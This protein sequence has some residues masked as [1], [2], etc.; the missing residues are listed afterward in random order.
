MP[1][2]CATESVGASSSGAPV[3]VLPASEWDREPY[4]G[5][6]EGN[7]F[8]AAREDPR[9]GSPRWTPL[10]AE[11]ATPVTTAPTSGPRRYRLSGIVGTAGGFVALIDADPRLP[12]AELYRVGDRVGPFV[13]TEANDSVVVLSGTSGT[14]VLRLETN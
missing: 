9:S 1:F 4:W 8:S 5:I 3:S 14:Q 7:V 12:G 2:N 11:S 13:L 6:V 10:V